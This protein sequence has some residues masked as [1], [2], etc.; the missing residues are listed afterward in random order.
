MGFDEQRQLCVTRQAYNHQ[1]TRRIKK[2]KKGRKTTA[3]S[4]ANWKTCR[5]EMVAKGPVAAERARHAMVV[6][7][8]PQL[9]F[10]PVS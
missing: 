2:G 3:N 9:L 4:V 8:P 5:G 6:V 7:M 1:Q 10:L